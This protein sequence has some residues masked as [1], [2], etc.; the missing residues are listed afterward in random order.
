M[1]ELMG[2]IPEIRHRLNC[3][4]SATRSKIPSR[5]KGQDERSTSA[6]IEALTPKELLTLKI[7]D[8]V[9]SPLIKDR[10]IIAEAKEAL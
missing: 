1:S 7:P 4:M 10:S 6:L 9:I 8:E 3:S 5:T 2:K